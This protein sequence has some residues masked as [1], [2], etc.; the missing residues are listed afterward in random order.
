MGTEGCQGVV[1]DDAV[2]DEV[3]PSSTVEHDSSTALFRVHQ[4]ETNARVLGEPR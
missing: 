4:K 1:A 2:V 3:A